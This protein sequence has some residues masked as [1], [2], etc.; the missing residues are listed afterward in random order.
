MKC[1]ALCTCVKFKDRLPYSSPQHGGPLLPGT[2]T[3]R[4]GVGK[5]RMGLALKGARNDKKEKSK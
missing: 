3:S 4:E 5:Y 1:K 2:G